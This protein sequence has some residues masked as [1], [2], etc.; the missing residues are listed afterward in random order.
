MWKRNLHTNFHRH[1]VETLSSLLQGV[2]RSR[3]Q[4]LHLPQVIAERAN[5]IDGQ[6]RPGS[7]TEVNSDPSSKVRGLLDAWILILRL[8]SFPKIAYPMAT[9]V[10]R[11]V[12]SPQPI[13]E[14]EFPLGLKLRFRSSLQRNASFYASRLVRVGSALT[15]PRH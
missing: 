6:S 11:F 15:Q 12:T 13:F 7:R 14:S 2:G 4:S 8:R 3:R 9:Q 1:V 10:R 5:P